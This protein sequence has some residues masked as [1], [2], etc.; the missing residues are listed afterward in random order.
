MD[1]IKA[2]KTRRSMRSYGTAPVPKAVLERV[3]EA[4]RLAPS[5]CNFQPWRFIVVED[6][7]MREAIAQTG[8]FA[9]FLAESPVVIVGCGDMKAS[10]KWHAVDVSIALEN[11]VITATAEGLGSCWIG[12]FDPAKVKELLKVPEGFVI[13]ALLALGYP[14]LAPQEAPPQRRKRMDEIVMIGEFGKPF[15]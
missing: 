15:G 2:I 12:S 4:G 13:V 10:P 14:K 1:V 6:R 11:M 9:H 7:S 3:L 5:A 8:R